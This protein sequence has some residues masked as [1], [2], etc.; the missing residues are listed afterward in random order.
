MLQ[1]PNSFRL[2]FTSGS[3]ASVALHVFVLAFIAIDLPELRAE[4]DEPEAIQVELVQPA[5]ASEPEPPAPP[6]PVAEPVPPEPPQTEPEQPV[7]APPPA[8]LRPV[9][10]FAEE[11]AGAKE[12]PEDAPDTEV[13]EDQ[14][15]EEVTDDETAE[16]QSPPEPEVAETSA[17]DPTLP[18]PEVA[19]TPAAEPEQLFAAIVRPATP[20]SRPAAEARS[21]SRNERS[22]ATTA[23]RDLTRAR[24]G[25]LL[26]HP[27]L[28][29]R[30]KIARAPQ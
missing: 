4:P 11:D 24:R 13:A 10:K 22:V 7:E 17:A 14:T 3:V 5:Q 2:K 29:R 15:P 9:T 8:V 12:P 20:V 26:C 21:Q 25:G 27:E 30:L 23:K 28:G 16:V 1:K 6:E 18:E 19:E